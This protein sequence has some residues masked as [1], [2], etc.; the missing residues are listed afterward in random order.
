LVY[1]KLYD[2]W[3]GINDP[4][5]QLE[6]F[7]GDRSP[8]QVKMAITNLLNGA[9]RTWP[10]VFELTDRIELIDTHLKICVSFLAKIK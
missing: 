7:V 1:A 10:G 3:K 8:E 5:Y 9:K 2:E 6:F 4:N